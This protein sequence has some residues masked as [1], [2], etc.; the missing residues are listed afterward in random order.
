MSEPLV[1]MVLMVATPWPLLEVYPMIR[2]LPAAVAGIVQVPGQFWEPQ[3][4]K[5]INA[6]AVGE[7]PVPV[8]VTT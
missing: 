2:A 8:S 4:V 5:L 3:A 7:V 6:I 1:V